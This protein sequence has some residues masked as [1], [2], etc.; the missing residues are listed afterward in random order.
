MPVFKK[1]AINDSR[2][3]ERISPK[4]LREA[5]AEGELPGETDCD[6][7]ALYVKTV[8][9]GITVQGASGLLAR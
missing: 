2:K 4:R 5:Q 3:G 8:A 1:N 7:L 9:L 6:A